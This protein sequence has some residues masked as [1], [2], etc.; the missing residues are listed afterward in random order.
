MIEDNRMEWHDILINPPVAPPLKGKSLEFAFSGLE[1]PSLYT[2]TM[3]G[4]QSRTNPNANVI[5]TKEFGWWTTEQW[6]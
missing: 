6:K 2:R 1:P 3:I 5:S 4:A